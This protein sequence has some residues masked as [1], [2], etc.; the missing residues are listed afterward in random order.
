[1][2]SRMD[3]D[4]GRFVLVVD[5]TEAGY[6]HYT[7]ENNPED[8]RHN[9]RVFDHTLIDERFRGQGLGSRLIEE[10]VKATEEAGFPYRATCSAVENWLAKHR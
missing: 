7:L 4:G 9:L 2:R 1:M 5:G 6:A 8:S 3:C 10:S